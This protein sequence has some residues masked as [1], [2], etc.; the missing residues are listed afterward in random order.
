MPSSM[1]GLSYLCTSRGLLLGTRVQLH[2][3]NSVIDEN[4]IRPILDEK[5]FSLFKV[6]EAYEYLEQPKHFSKVVVRVC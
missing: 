3:M 5:V 4:D 1:D 2:A 6:R